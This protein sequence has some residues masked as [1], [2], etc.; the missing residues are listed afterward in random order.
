MSKDRSLFQEKLVGLYLRL[1]GY[2]QTGYIPHSDVWG[3]NGTDFD[4]C[5]IRFPKHSQ[6]ERGIGD[7]PALKVP[8]G[9]I[10]I[11]LA[12][13]KNSALTFNETIKTNGLRAVENWG[14]FLRWA[15]L[16]EEDEINIIIPKLLL[17]IDEDGIKDGENFKTVFHKTAFG[18]V[19]IRPIIFSIEVVH[20]KDNLKIWINGKEVIDY[21]WTC[22][23][24]DT[25]RVDCSTRYSFEAW[26]FEYANLVQE[27]KDRHKQNL[28]KPSTTDLYNKFN[29]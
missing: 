15:G 16:F 12:E 20:D 5:A 22:L 18:E 7:C 8:A 4:R 10:D 28:G 17:L 6:P 19:T 2:F 24:P 25:P 29:V 13:V 3:Q 11:V 21:I 9:T 26:G 23:C 27:F 14:Q 1:N